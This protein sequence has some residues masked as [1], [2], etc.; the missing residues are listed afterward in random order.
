MF[1]FLGKNAGSL[2][3]HFLYVLL[4]CLANKEPCVFHASA[5]VGAFFNALR[6]ALVVAKQTETAKPFC[7]C[8]TVLPCVNF[9]S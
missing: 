8:R 2:L 7:I 3:K 5:L 9:Y 4:N 6:R 1:L